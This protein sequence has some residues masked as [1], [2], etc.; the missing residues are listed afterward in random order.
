MLEI[1]SL[2]LAL[3]DGDVLMACVKNDG[4]SVCIPA[5]QSQLGSGWRVDPRVYVCVCV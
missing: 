2:R 4:R 5:D 3:G 1:C